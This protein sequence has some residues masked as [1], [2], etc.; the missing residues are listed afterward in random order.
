[1]EPVW[2]KKVVCKACDGEFLTP[3]IRS[4]TLKIKS[5]DSDFK[6]NYDC[7]VNP[8]L[9]AVTSCPFCNYSARNE[10]FDKQE[11]DYHPEIIK[12]AA[13]IKEAKKNIV[14]PQE[15]EVTTKQ[16]EQK[17]LLAITFYNQYKPPNFNTIS[18]LYMHLA[19]IFRDEKNIE[20]EQEYLKKALE[21]YILTFEKGNFIPETI[22]EPGIMYLI[23]EINR[24]LGN[25]SE[26]VQWFS[27]VVKHNEIKSYPNIEHLTRDAWE[28]I[29]EEK[30]KNAIK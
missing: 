24:K 3:R 30:K 29:N 21:N 6:K 18:G 12:L 2:L 25:L 14:F 10:E 19:W 13:A 17:H 5:V 20:K 26:S 8:L 15:K 16:A 11:L 4:S 9:Y 7:A 23:G 22:G 27:K 28:K 1:M